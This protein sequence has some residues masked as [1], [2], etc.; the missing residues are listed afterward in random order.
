VSN[1]GE[2]HRLVVEENPGVLGPAEVERR[3][4]ALS[5]LKVHPRDELVNTALL[6]RAERLYEENL[7][8]RRQIVGQLISHFELA[9]AGQ[10]TRQIDAMRK[11][12][13]TR[14]NELE[15]LPCL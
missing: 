5:A 13:D 4:H 2:K 6:A 14:L 11:E 12:V 15:G 3:L 1:T 10:D 8:E 7:G 9:L